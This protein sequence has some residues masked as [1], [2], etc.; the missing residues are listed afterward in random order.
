M[1][2]IEQLKKN[3][4]CPA[5]LEQSGG[6]SLL[7]LVL[8]IAIFSISSFAMAT[9]LIDS[10]ISTRLSLDR[11]DAL[12]YAKEGMEAVRSIRDNNWSIWSA[13]AD[14][15]YGLLIDQSS[16]T[17]KFNGTSD[18]IDNK[19][20]RTV[21]IA[22]DPV[23]S[24]S[25]DVSVN[26]AWNLTPSRLASTTLSSVFSNWISVVNAD[27]AVSNG[28][29]SY[30]SFDGNANDSVGVYNGTVNGATLA[31]GV[32][33]AANTAYSFNGSSD[34]I[35][36][37]D[38]PISYPFTYSAWVNM[39]SSYGAG[40]VVVAGTYQPS[41]AP[42]LYVSDSGKIGVTLLGEVKNEAGL[43]SV[44]L[45]GWHMVTVVLDGANIYFYIDGIPDSRVSAPFSDSF[46][47]GPSYIGGFYAPNY[48]AYWSLFPG[49]I[50]N[51]RI[52]GRALSSGEVTT[53]YNAEK[54]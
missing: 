54:P 39:N 9:M 47:T 8:A 1:N 23:I 2:F 27:L 22:T 19:Y 15:N 35:S 32:K 6:F 26:V 20:T 11:T 5:K 10:N 24:S 43:D 49:L 34:Y 13:L 4:A 45:N 14:G 44:P 7:E 29:T 46:T 48:N 36:L 40:G 18:L 33:G 41:N 51:V 31:T 30:Y 16:S 28:L 38:V 50:D 3:K 53:I 25:K 52:Y 21:N 17:W 42:A 12:N 37:G